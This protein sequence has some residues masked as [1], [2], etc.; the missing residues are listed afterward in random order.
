MNTNRSTS[1]ISRLAIAITL[2][3]AI[4]LAGCCGG[5]ATQLSGAD[6]RSEIP[7]EG[8]ADRPPEE[9]PEKTISSTCVG[10]LGTG[11]AAFEEAYCDYRDA[12]RAAVSGTDGMAGI[13]PDLLIVDRDAIELFPADPAAALALLQEAS[14][15]LAG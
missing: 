9:L 1:P 11:D 4:A 14:A 15:K 13:D 2:V 5:G 12:V 7:E 8:D 6:V 10:A 3:S